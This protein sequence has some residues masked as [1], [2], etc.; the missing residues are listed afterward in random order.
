MND[1]SVIEALLFANGKALNIKKIV[2][3]TGIS[4]LEIK[5][6]IN[7]LN[8]IYQVNNSA[9]LIIEVN[10]SYQLVVK[11][12]FKD[13]IV[14]LFKEY[15][16]DTLTKTQLEVLSIIAYNQYISKAKIEKIKGNNCDRVIK[17]LM[18]L[19]LIDYKIDKDVNFKV[20]LY[21]TKDDFLKKFGMKNL[22]E[23]PKL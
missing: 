21:Y 22:S 20:K 19:N 1:K 15:E 4:K 9:F 5:N 3:I 7:E 17:T 12:I 13:F 14:K 6:Y 10:D 18:D 23:L 11:P 2:E 16:T 8:K